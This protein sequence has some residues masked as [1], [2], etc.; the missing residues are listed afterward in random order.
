MSVDVGGIRI[1][2]KPVR[3]SQTFVAIDAGRFMPAG[4][5]QRRVERLVSTVKS[6]APAKGNH[7]V[8]VAG[9]PEWHAERER[10]QSGIPLGDGT[11]HCLGETATRLGYAPPSATLIKP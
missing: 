6:A 11:W 4:E 7:E 8:L 10:R 2:G 1:Q 3:A 9:D 5:F